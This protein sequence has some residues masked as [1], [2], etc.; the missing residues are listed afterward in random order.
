MRNMA[1]NAMVEKQFSQNSMNKSRI[2][3]PAGREFGVVIGI[4]QKVY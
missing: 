4:L 2:L 3:R 1:A